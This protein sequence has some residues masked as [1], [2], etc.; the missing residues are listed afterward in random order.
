MLQGI[1]FCI[2][3]DIPMT[4]SLIE[5]II[6]RGTSYNLSRIGNGIAYIGFN[7]SRYEDNSTKIS[8]GYVLLN[9]YT[10]IHDIII[11][12]NLGYIS[13]YGIDCF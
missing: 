5:G 10:I 2:A 9:S 6:K 8:L 3:L 11:T 13:C 4:D 1:R 7:H 12:I